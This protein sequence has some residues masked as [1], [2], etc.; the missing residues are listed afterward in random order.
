MEEKTPLLLYKVINGVPYL[1]DEQMLVMASGQ[2]VYQR[3]AASESA[4][5]WQAGTF[6]TALSPE[7]TTKAK[8][9]GVALAG[10]TPD[11]E[12]RFRRVIQFTVTG[13]AGEDQQTH[14]LHHLPP[15]ELPPVLKEA[16]RLYTKLQGEAEAAPLAVVELRAQFNQPLKGGI[17][18]GKIRLMLRVHNPG[19]EPVS[20]MFHD[21]AFALAARTADGLKPLW[22]SGDER[23]T[24]FIDTEG[25]LVDGIRLPAQLAP[26]QGAALLIPLESSPDD[27]ENIQVTA[28]GE[29]ELDGA[30]REMVLLSEVS[31][32]S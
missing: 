2:V 27:N 29:I 12:R 1:V 31:G 20:F 16:A 17:A 9:L 25:R 30:W 32:V 15:D 18:P 14:P 24:G 3:A 13:F 22:E 5:R 23:M 28:V 11:E 21:G 6:T 26:G 7:E 19:S 4:R 10:L 8:E